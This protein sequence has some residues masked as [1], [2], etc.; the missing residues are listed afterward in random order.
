MAIGSAIAGSALGSGGGGGGGGAIGSAIGA[1]GGA[2]GGIALLAGAAG[3]GGKEELKRALKLWEQ[4]QEPDFNFQDLTPP[5]LELLAEATPEIF[6]AAVPGAAALPEDSPL[7]RAQQAQALG[8]LGRVAEE[9]LPEADRLS[10]AIAGRAVRGAA[11]A[12][13]EEIIQN[14]RRRGR[15]GAGAETQARA[16]GG[17]LSG[18]LAGEMGLNLQRESQARRLQALRDFGGAAGALRGQDIGLSAGRAQALNRFNE[19]VA[20]QRQQAGQYGAGARERAQAYNVGTQQRL[21]EQQQLADYQAAMANVNRQ[22]QLQQQL[23]G[24][25]LAKVQGQTGALG[26]LSTAQYAEQAARA[27]AVRGAAGGG[28]KA[29]GGAYQA[30]GGQQAGGVQQPPPLQYGSNTQ[31]Y[32]I[33]GPP[34]PGYYH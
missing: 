6:E 29:A 27:A 11:Q 4:L 20:A 34:P 3:E 1:A 15:L 33:Y 19:F 13:N 17:R 22:N 23:F 5:Q 32:P 7:V 26:D 18:Q 21:G 2:I 31:P 24:S 25:R 12:G 16:V 30:F 28:A 9:G 14:L 10:A 8:G